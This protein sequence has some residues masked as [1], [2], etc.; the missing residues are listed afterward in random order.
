MIAEAVE[1]AAAREIADEHTVLT[2]VEERPCF[3]T[4]ARR[5]EESDSVLVDLDLVGHLAA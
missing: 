5:G 4:E 3:L 1:C 2:L